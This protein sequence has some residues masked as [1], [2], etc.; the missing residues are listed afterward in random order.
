[1]RGP[2]PVITWSHLPSLTDT[3]SIT[4]QGEMHR[5]ESTKHSFQSLTDL[6]TGTRCPCSLKWHNCLEN[7]PHASPNQA[8]IRPFYFALLNVENWTF[9]SVR[10]EERERERERRERGERERG[11]RERERERE[12]KEKGEEKTIGRAVCLCCCLVTDSFQ[13]SWLIGHVQVRLHLPA[14]R[15]RCYLHKKVQQKS[16]CPL[17]LHPSHPH[18]S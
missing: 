7:L 10:E 17:F 14:K 9:V 3:F 16:S 11:E 6:F 15:E 12:R 18:L 2:A 5:G 1:M 13:L 8:N 4:L